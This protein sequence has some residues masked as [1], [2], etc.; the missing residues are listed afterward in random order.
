MKNI[1]DYTTELVES[2]Q[3]TLDGMDRAVN[4]QGKAVRSLRR[5]SM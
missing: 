2:K 1:L 4:G 5:V 3:L